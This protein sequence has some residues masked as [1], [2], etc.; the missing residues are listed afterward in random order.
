MKNNHRIPVLMTRGD[1][2]ILKSITPSPQQYELSEFTEELNRA[3]LVQ[4]YAF[5]HHAIR[6]YSQVTLQD[7]S[8]NTKTQ[9][10]IVLPDEANEESARK[11]VLEPLATA[12]LG[13]R[14]GE[15]IVW[16]NAKG[17]GKFKIVQVNNSQLP[18]FQNNLHPKCID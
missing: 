14:E 6:L 11:S 3:I 15:E 17:K 2:G 9:F 5:P 16:A 4:D 10:T 7:E 12:V 8:T 18:V 1:Y 13:F